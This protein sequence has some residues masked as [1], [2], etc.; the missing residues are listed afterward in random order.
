MLTNHKKIKEWLDNYQADCY[1]IR[2]DGVVDVG[3]FNAYNDHRLTEIP[4]QFGTASGLFSVQGTPLTSLKGVPRVVNGMF[5]CSNTKITTL[6]HAPAIIKTDFYCNDN[7]HIKSM[8]GTDKI[9]KQLDGRFHCYST[10][11]NNEKKITPTHLLG[12]LLIEGITW[13]YFEDQIVSKIM[14]KYCGTGDIL[15]A[16]DEL[17]D[18]GF[19][20]QARL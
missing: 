19:T 7:T 4:I 6:E 12:L 11:I 14:T 17:I 8:S 13:F 20:D 15:S 10:T 3:I 1:T 9:I 5:S 16:Q 2:R 18:A